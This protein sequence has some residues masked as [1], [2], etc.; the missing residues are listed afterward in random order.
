MAF[1]DESVENIVAVGI[2]DH[3]SARIWFRA[4]RPGSYVLEVSGPGGALHGR[5]TAQISNGNATDNTTTVLYPGPGRDLAPLTRYDVKIASEDGLVF[6]GEAQFETAPATPNDVP[7]TFSIGVFSCHQPFSS[8]GDLS[9]SSMRLLGQLP[10]YFQD[11]TVKFV[12]PV[13]DQI[14]ADEPGPFSLMSPLYGQQRWGKPLAQLSPQE[15]RAAFQERYRI[16]WNQRPWLKLLS[17]YPSYA[18]L[19]DHEVFDDWGSIAAH[20]DEPYRTIIQAGR[21]AYL[22]YQGSRQLPW[23]DGAAAP[24]ALDYSFTY[25]TVA[26]YVFDL[27]SE[28]RLLPEPRVISDEQLARFEQFLAA[29]RDAHVILA[30]TSVPLVH[31]PEWVT[32][33]GEE[34]V[35]TGV[36]FPDHWSAPRNRANRDQ[37]LTVIH[38][39]LSRPETRRQRFVVVGGDVHVGCAFTLRFVG[40]A[41]PLMYELTTSSVSNRIQGWHADASMLGPESFAI[42]RRMANDKLDV[43]LLPPAQGRGQRNPTAELNAGII[44]C[45]RDGEQTNIRLKLLGPGNGGPSVDFESAWL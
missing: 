17:S 18:I 29:N 3:R 32:A 38:D 22:D 20:A 4:E 5:T 19:D 21:L 1:G 24:A 26:T 43:A 10:Q 14:Y 35:G 42:T 8:E 37:V 40:G 15:M 12:L 39:H 31:I 2:V 7:A 45:R 41:K 16:F 25:G 13:G 9:A 11:N 30:V 44:E 36:D 33:L 28:R 34:L 6:V 23:G 27:R